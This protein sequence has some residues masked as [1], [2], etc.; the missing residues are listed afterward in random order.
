MNITPKTQKYYN[1]HRLIPKNSF[2]TS[3]K[4]PN[5]NSVKNTNKKI[6]ELIKNE[7]TMWTPQQEQL[8]ICWAEKASGY[9][10][11]HNKCINFYK[12]RNRIISIPA[13]IFGYISGTATL[14]TSG[15]HQY[16]GLT[17]TIGICGIMAGILSNLQQMFTYKELSE[18]HRISSLRFQ[19]FFRDISCEL[20]LNPKYRSSP[21]DYIKMKRLEFDKMLEQSPDIPEAIIQQFHALFRHKKIHKPENT[22]TLQT[23]ITYDQQLKK[24]NMN[25]DLYINNVNSNNVIDSSNANTDIIKPINP[26]DLEN[27]NRH[28]ETKSLDNMGI[29]GVI[30]N[31]KGEGMVEIANSTIGKDVILDM[32]ENNSSILDVASTDDIFMSMVDINTK[33]VILKEK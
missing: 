13:S 1:T 30:S 3:N 21:I 17:A 22:N 10:W 6:D 28:N 23:I 9:S 18:Q 4:N 11:L 5:K 19:S 2:K 27:N 15:M 29:T 16:T 24:L 31:K 32:N 14:L 20:S 26:V 7:K 25:F 33:N 8:L 12:T